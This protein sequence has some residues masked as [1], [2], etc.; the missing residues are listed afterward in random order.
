MEVLRRGRMPF[1]KA[2]KDFLT[3]PGA[4]V[5]HGNLRIMQDTVRFLLDNRHIGRQ[6]S[7]ATDTIIKHLQSQKHNIHRERW[8]TDVLG[9]MKENGIFIGSIIGL[10]I[11]IIKDEDD[12]RSV[13]RSHLRRIQVETRRMKELE[14]LA[15]QHGW[16]L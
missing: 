16:K 5:S 7:V 2:A 4:L 14:R 1:V 13:H 12:A 9:P 6:K 3:N 11:F 15:K 8:Q 10:G